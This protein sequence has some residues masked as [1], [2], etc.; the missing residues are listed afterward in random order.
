[1]RRAP[2]M[3]QRPSHSAAG[4]GL[5]ARERIEADQWI[6]E[7]WGDLWETPTRM[8][9]QFGPHEHIDPSHDCLL[10]YLNQSCAPNA[11]FRD[12]MLQARRAIET[13]EE[14]TVDYACTEYELSAP[15]TCRCGAER[16][17][18]RIEGYRLLTPEQR[19]ARKPFVPDWLSESD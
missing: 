19:A 1:M 11:Y 7:F 18:G 6:G 10:R 2:K 13:G 16:C 17:I 4:M 15:F 14:I 12:R 3:E 8:S 9:V 5:F